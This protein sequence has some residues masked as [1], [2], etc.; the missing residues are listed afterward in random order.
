MGKFK[1]YIRVIDKREDA[2]P[3]PPPPFDI[4]KMKSTQEYVARVY[5]IDA[6]HLF[7]AD[8][9]GSADPYLALKLGRGRKKKVGVILFF[10]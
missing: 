9:D 7:P 1:G 5:V 3:P 2:P 6:H 8:E 4:G 10:A